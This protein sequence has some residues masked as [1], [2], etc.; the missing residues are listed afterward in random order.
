[1]FLVFSGDMY[2]TKEDMRRDQKLQAHLPRVNAEKS[3]PPPPPNGHIDYSAI[4]R[5]FTFTWR[6]FQYH[7]LGDPLRS[8]FTNIYGAD[9]ESE[10]E[11]D[12]TTDCEEIQNT[13]IQ[14]CIEELVS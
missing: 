7:Y 10:D 11:F 4:Q 8:M 3:T 9:D 2:I 14:E 1:M 6:S 13:P 5:K 12:E